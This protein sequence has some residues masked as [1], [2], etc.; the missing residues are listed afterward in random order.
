[1]RIAK[2][3]LNHYEVWQRNF[4][5][6]DEV[7]WVCGGRSR[8]AT[9]WGHVDLCRGHFL[10][11]PIERLRRLVTILEF[12]CTAVLC[13]GR[14]VS[15]A[16]AIVVTFS[17]PSRSGNHE[18]KGCPSSPKSKRFNVGIFKCSKFQVVDKSISCLLVDIDP[19]SMSNM[20]IHA[21]YWTTNAVYGTT[22]DGC[23][24]GNRYEN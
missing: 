18:H 16:Y 9:E 17:R 11:H 21:V 15:E 4:L 1:M 13:S 8:S 19:I 14:L 23:R 5:F 2:H 12:S 22:R 7:G 6:R 3:V 10:L 20:L 24:G